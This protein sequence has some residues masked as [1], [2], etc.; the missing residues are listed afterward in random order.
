[1]RK[2]EPFTLYERRF[3][4]GPV[5][6][7][8]VYDEYGDRRPG[9]STGQVTKAD[10]Y[11]W[12]VREFEAGRLGAGHD[13]TLREW[14]ESRH[15]WQ[16]GKCDYIR[17]KLARSP[18]DKPA[19]GRRHAD[20]S[21]EKLKLHILPYLG[22]L[23]LS[24][25][26][27]VV[28]ERW[29]FDRLQTKAPKTV[30]NVTSV[31]RVMIGEA[32]RLEMIS[33]NPFDK[34]RPL[35]P[36]TKPRGIL[37]L[38]EARTLL[39]PATRGEVWREH[40]YY[41]ANLIAATTGMRLSEILAL[42]DNDIR[43]DHI[44]VTKRW[45]LKYGEGPTKTKEPRVVPLPGFVTALLPSVTGYILSHTD[46]AAPLTGGRVLDA[47][48]DAMDSVGIEDYRQRRVTFHSWRHFANTYFRS[49]GVP[50]SKV[51][52]VTGHK[53]QAMTDHYTHYRPEDFA[54][55]VQAQAGMISPSE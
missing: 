41:C 28:I 53:T 38:E 32:Y 2:R 23:R 8:R 18:K 48:Y 29:M 40:E 42:T 1:M 47:L 9:R 20:K 37:T 3:K 26:T 27:P 10:A 13:P 22:D 43:T 31:L 46:G 12:C 17:G 49:A 39:N 52:S 25:L 24:Q 51:Q 44:I 50:D 55:V 34:V 33:R 19:I 36:D 5:W 15:W 11:R 35:H 54:E 7:Y 6:Y 4:H 14:S 16:W 21:L 45:D 30:N